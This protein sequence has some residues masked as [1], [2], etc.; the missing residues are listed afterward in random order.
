[1]SRSLGLVDVGSAG[2][3]AH[4]A[5]Q[6]RMTKQGSRSDF[7]EARLSGGNG[8]ATRTPCTSPH[9]ESC[10]PAAAP[11]PSCP[12]HVADARLYFPLKHSKQPLLPGTPVASVA[13]PSPVGTSMCTGPCARRS[14]VRNRHSSACK[15]ACSGLVATSSASPVQA[16]DTSAHNSSPQDEASETPGEPAVDGWA[17]VPPGFTELSALQ[18]GPL[19]PARVAGLPPSSFNSDIADKMNGPHYCCAEMP[20]AVGSILDLKVAAVN[21]A[22]MACQ[23]SH[24]ELGGVPGSGSARGGLSCADLHNDNGNGG[25]ESFTADGGDESFTADDGDESFTADDGDEAF[26]SDKRRCRSYLVQHDCST[27]CA[28]EMR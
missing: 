25:D 13:A 26:K 21:L 8:S 10:A 2:A 27:G 19:Q 1:M 12:T 14:S 17:C 5:Y 3:S 4:G 9:S 16:V 23:G 15:V 7:L 24:A 22:A 20:A 18:R 28:I 6:S 11:L